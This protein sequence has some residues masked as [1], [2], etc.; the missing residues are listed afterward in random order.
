MTTKFNPG[1]VVNIIDPLNKKVVTEA[2]ITYEFDPMKCV[3]H[4]D[5][6]HTDH[7]EWANVLGLNGSWYMH[8]PEC[9]M[10]LSKFGKALRSHEH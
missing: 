8:V 7:V 9:N 10:E 4:A 3:L 5:Y 1:D 6:V 2:V